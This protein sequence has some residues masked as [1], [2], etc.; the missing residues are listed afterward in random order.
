MLWIDYGGA[1]DG[2]L[3]LGPVLLLCCYHLRWHGGLDSHYPF[4][5]AAP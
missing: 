4:A 3:H 5:P 2:H 1:Y